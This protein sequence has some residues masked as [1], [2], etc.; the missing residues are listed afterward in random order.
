MR[1]GDSVFLTIDLNPYIEKIYNVDNL[2]INENINVK[3]SVYNPGSE[4]IISAVI[5]NMFNE[6]SFLTGLLGGLNGKYYHKKLLE[7]NIP[8][9]FIY[10]KEETRARISMNDGI[11]HINIYEEN[12]RITRDDILD[13]FEIYSKLIDKSNIIYGVS[14]VLP[15]GFSEEIYYN[16][17]RLAKAKNKRFILNA[18]SLELKKAVDAAPYMVILDKEQL[19]YLL[20]IKLEFENEIIKGSRYLLDRGVE[21]VVVDLSMDET[22][23]L[24]RDHGYRVQ[25]AQDIDIKATSRENGRCSIASGFGL[26]MSRQYSMEMTLSLVQ[27]IKTVVNLQEDISKI[28]INQIKRLMNEVEIFN[29][30]Y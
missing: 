9:D 16:L 7:L 18:K 12:P 19:E 22:L 13:F 1:G 28:E 29:I 24:C 20:N 3:N 2:N 6:R 14:N 25:L 26:G 11:N 21:F 15:P 17:I 27:A 10:I 4:S 23:V 5:L 8:H 30:N